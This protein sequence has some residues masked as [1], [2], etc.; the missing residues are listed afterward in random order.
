MNQ[1]CAKTNAG[2]VL[3]LVPLTVDILT[4]LNEFPGLMVE[5]FYVKFGYPRCSYIGNIVRINRQTDKLQ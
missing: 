3:C 4:P 5:H 2:T 1:N